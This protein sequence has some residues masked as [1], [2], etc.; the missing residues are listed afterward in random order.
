MQQRKRLP[1]TVSTEATRGIHINQNSICYESLVMCVFPSKKNQFTMKLLLFHL[2]LEKKA[3]NEYCS[4]S[5]FNAHF[6]I[7]ELRG[8][9][10]FLHCVKTAAFENS[11]DNVT[12]EPC[13]CYFKIKGSF[14]SFQKQRVSKTV[15]DEK[16]CFS[17]QKENP[18]LGNDIIQQ[19][20]DFQTATFRTVTYWGVDNAHMTPQ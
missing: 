18:P 2:G 16:V 10:P 19:L 13:K 3:C 1:I 8:L 11:F 7:I 20:L 5:R 17:W 14:L 9:S 15:K 6:K 12:A 4:L